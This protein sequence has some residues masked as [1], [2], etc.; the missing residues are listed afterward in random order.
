MDG[1]SLMNDAQQK[2]LFMLADLQPR[3]QNY[4]IENGIQIAAGNRE[5]CQ[6][7]SSRIT[8]IIVSGPCGVGA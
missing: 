5:Q 1:Q 8:A 6:Q 7:A 4:T 3:Q 2:A